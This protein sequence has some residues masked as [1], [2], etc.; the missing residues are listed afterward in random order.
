MYLSGMLGTPTKTDGWRAM[1]VYIEVQ[2]RVA[3]VSDAGNHVIPHSE[4]IACSA[5]P[6]AA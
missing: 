3:G 6:I 4:C 5:V 2:V 1:V